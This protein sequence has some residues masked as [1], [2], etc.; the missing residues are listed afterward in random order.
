MFNECLEI[1]PKMRIF[2]SLTSPSKISLF[3]KP[4][5]TFDTVFHLVVK[6]RVECLI[7]LLKQ[8]HF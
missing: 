2:A 5:Q 4:Y 3:E 1:R 7:F 6:H 8:N